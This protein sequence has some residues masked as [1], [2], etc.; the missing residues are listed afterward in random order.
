MEHQPPGDGDPAISGWITRKKGST[1]LLTWLW[2]RFQM[3]GELGV[4]R[5]EEEGKSGEKGGENRTNREAKVS[6]SQVFSIKNNRWNAKCKIKGNEQL[7][8]LLRIFITWILHFLR[9]SWFRIHA[10]CTEEKGDNM[11]RKKINWKKREENGAYSTKWYI[12]CI[13]LGCLGNLLRALYIWLVV[14]MTS[15][16]TMQN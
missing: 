15:V 10:L 5:W 14:H 12:Y 9:S 13:F 2:R 1:E 8:S 6:R 7:R 3:N 16:A 4:K 11:Y